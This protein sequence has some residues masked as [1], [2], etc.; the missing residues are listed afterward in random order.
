M[1]WLIGYLYR[2]SIPLTGG[3]DGAFT[4]FQLKLAIAFVTGHMQS[5]FDDIRFT[6]ADG[7]TLIDAWLEDKTDGTSADVVVEFINTPAD[8]VTETK[9]YMY[10]G[11]AD[12]VNYWD[13]GATFLLGDDFSEASLDTGKWTDGKGTGVSIDSGTLK[14][15]NTDHITGTNCVYSNIDTFQDVI[16][17]MKVKRSANGNGIYFGVR[18]DE[19]FETGYSVFDSDGAHFDL[20]RVN[21]IVATS[22]FS[23]STDT[24]YNVK[25]IAY[26]VQGGAGGIKAG[27]STEEVSSY[28][29]D[30]EDADMLPAD[31][32]VMAG[33]T[34]G[35][36]WYDDVRVSKYAANPPTYEFGSEEIFRYGIM[37]NPAMTGGMV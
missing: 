36:H 13:I 2:K 19:T 18:D 28:L 3:S 34:E 6:Q 20:R 17:E 12:A 22:S 37:R 1:A 31:R 15:D 9:G 25:I 29:I 33:Y 23:W 7:T 10:Y 5:D 16:L 21:S 32:V 27:I 26:G 30:Y 11:K 24:W 35:N 4:D 8:G 14:L